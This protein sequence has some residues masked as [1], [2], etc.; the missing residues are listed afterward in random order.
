MTIKD[1]FSAKKGNPFSSWFQNKCVPTLGFSSVRRVCKPHL[2]HPDQYQQF[3]DHT[4][5]LFLADDKICPCEKY[6]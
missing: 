1:D 2:T 3:V 5:A 6:N 4:K